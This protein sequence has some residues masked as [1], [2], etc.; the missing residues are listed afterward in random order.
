[1]EELKSL[2]KVSG[3]KVDLQ[4]DGGINFETAPAAIAAG[5]DILVAGTAAFAGGE[6]FYES[7]LRRL[8]G[9]DG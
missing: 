4:V 5:A 1:M 8:Q 9:I 6:E 2:I 7:N 3:R